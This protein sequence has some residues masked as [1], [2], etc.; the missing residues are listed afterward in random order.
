[1]YIIAITENHKFAY[2][3]NEEFKNI[4]KSYSSIKLNVTEVTTENYLQLKNIFK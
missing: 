4:N 1:M 3:T 2:F